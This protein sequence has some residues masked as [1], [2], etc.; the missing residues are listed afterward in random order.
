MLQV[1]ENPLPP[2]LLFPKS[3]ESNDYVLLD[4]FS[5]TSFVLDDIAATFRV[6]CMMNW[7]LMVKVVNGTKSIDIKDLNGLFSRYGLKK[8]ES[9]AAADEIHCKRGPFN[10]QKRVNA[11]ARSS[12]ETSQKQSQKHDSTVT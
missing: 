8:R 2:F 1:P 4:T 6:K 5:T 3:A 7:K 10:T 11:W 9:R 12:L